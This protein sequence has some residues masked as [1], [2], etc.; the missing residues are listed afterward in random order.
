MV[1]RFY[2]ESW[3]AW[4]VQ[5]VD[6]IRWFAHEH[7]A[8]IQTVAD[9]ACGTG[10]LVKALRENGYEVVGLDRSPHMIERASAANP[11]IP[12]IVGDMSD[13]EIPDLVDLAICA[14]DSVNYLTEQDRLAAAFSNIL[15]MLKRRAFFTFDVNTPYLYETRQ[16][17]TIDREVGGVTFRQILYYDRSHRIA[18]TVFDFGGDDQETHVQRA[19][20]AVEVDE[21]LRRAGFEILHA[22][23]DFDRSIPGDTSTRTIFV[24][25]AP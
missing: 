16:H 15:G 22:F 11:G 3:S 24:A 17:G 25:R 8:R 14:F 5:Y 10:V 21:S 19:Y 13:T 7:D 12:F 1:S 20:E 4:G 9:I 6:L 2:D 23:A 18:T